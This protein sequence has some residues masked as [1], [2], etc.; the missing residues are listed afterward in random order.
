MVLRAPE[1]FLLH[2]KSIIKLCEASLFLPNLNSQLLSMF[3]QDRF[4]NI[5]IF[6]EPSNLHVGEVVFNDKSLVWQDKEI[7]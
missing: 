7:K 1:L 2:S 5:K 3:S 4:E 6:H